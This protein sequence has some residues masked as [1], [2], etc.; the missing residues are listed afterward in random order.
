MLIFYRMALNVC[1]DLRAPKNLSRSQIRPLLSFG[2]WLTVTN[3]VG[4]LM[5]YMDR[6]FIS[7]ILGLVAVAYY[8]APYEMLARVQ[9]IPQ[10][11]L[12]V[13]FP[14][15]SLANS[16]NGTRLASLFS[17]V[18][19]ILYWAM[20]PVLTTIFLLGPEILLFWL[21]EDFRDE[22]SNV[23]RWLSVGWMINILAQPAFVFLQSAGRPD[24][25]AKAHVAELI[26]YV[27]VLYWLSSLYGI[28]GAAATWALRIAAD[29]LL[30]NF[31][32]VKVNSSL[33]SQVRMNLVLMVC[34]I[35]FF[36]LLTHIDH[37]AIKLIILL[38]VGSLSTRV[39][40][41]EFMKSK[42]FN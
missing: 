35:F 24:L 1:D 21:G 30:L 9:L 28:A 33:L 17:D 23:I 40:L 42:E 10:A 3:I 5:T 16:N 15:L 39:L 26:P 32:A 11:I 12:G 4:P 34:S 2:G 31:L 27:A 14:A 8:V 20:L 36:W 41:P 7:S 25:T 19:K 6:F 13:I 38:I 29:T 22:S 18:S 37:M